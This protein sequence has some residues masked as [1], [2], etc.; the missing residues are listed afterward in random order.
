M[1]LNPGEVL[2]PVFHFLDDAIADYGVYLY[3]ALVWLCVIVIAW[4]FSGG[5]RRKIRHQP[6]ITS[7]IGI[8]IL[9]PTRQPP[10]T[11][12]II[13]HELDPSRDDDDG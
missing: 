9:P 8:V 6:H 2:N 7:S 4:I 10:P 1:N 12:P 3:I 11:P 13:M 5:L